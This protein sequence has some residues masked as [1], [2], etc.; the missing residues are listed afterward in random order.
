L[1]LRAMLDGGEFDPYARSPRAP[2]HR[3][4]ATRLIIALDPIHQREREL[5]SWLR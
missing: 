2:L 5:A 4:E 1:S 3:R